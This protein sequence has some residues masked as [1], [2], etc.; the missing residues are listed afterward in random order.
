MSNPAGARIVAACAKSCI[1][2][3]IP[4]DIFADFNTAT[5]PDAAFT[6]SICSSDNPVVHRTTGIFLSTL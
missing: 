5:C 4:S 3:L 2:R 6:C 1:S